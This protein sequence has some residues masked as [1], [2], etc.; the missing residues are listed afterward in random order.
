MKLQLIT[1][2]SILKYSEPSFP[3]SQSEGKQAYNTYVFNQ[4]IIYL[5]AYKLL[6]E[7]RNEIIDKNYFNEERFLLA[8]KE[9]KKYLKKLL[10][11]EEVNL[12]QVVKDYYYGALTILMKYDEGFLE[13]YPSECPYT[14]KQIMEK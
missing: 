12:D 3:P 2:Q 5:V 9:V 6:K 11:K 8:R 7:F 14:F 10:S 13:N 4:N 1:L